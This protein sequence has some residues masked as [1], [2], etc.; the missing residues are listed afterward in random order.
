MKPLEEN[1]RV[2]TLLTICSPA[3]SISRWKK[4]FY[5]FL[6]ISYILI[7]FI[8][9]IASFAFVLKYFSTD[10]EN[11]ICACLQIVASMT[12]IYSFI[13][14]Y[15]NCDEFKEIFDNFQIFL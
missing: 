14:A 10:L 11:A 9:L 12:A 6:L 8:L 1:Y 5:F 15:I 7:Q 3:K 2:F 13:T 4:L